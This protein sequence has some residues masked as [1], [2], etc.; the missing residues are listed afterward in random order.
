MVEIY[1]VYVGSAHKPSAIA[2]PCIKLAEHGLSFDPGLAWPDLAWLD[3]KSITRSQRLLKRFDCIKIAHM[4]FASSSS[5]ATYY[6]Y[7]LELKR[8]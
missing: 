6:Y 2:R 7:P 8:R 3:A 5:S 1:N 4:E